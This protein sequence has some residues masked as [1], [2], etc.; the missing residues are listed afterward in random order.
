MKENAYYG[1][2]E[3]FNVGKKYLRDKGLFYSLKRLFFYLWDKV[4]GNFLF[5]KEKKIFLFDNNKL[6][7]SFHKYNKSWKNERIVEIPIA[8]FYLK[9]YYSKEVLEVG[10]VLGHY[11]SFEHDVL[12][13]YE[14]AEGIMNYDVIDFVPLKKYDL[15][16]SISTFEHVGVDD[17]IQNP[18]NAYLGL[19][20]IFKSLNEGGKM[21]ISFPGNYNLA[22]MDMV[23]NKKL[24]NFKVFCF[25]KNQKKNTWFQVQFEKVVDIPYQQPVQAVIFVEITK[26][27]TFL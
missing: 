8:M 16:L 14:I 3:F 23:K 22:L 15:I 12:D 10:N 4:V 1:G 6:H 17:D 26:D 13:K 25:K 19:K 5:L 21:L 11:F 27:T 20:N 7:Y 18:E 9:N 24:K 2:E